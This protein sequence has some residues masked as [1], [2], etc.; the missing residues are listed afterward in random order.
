MI[1][2]AREIVRLAAA[3]RQAIVS[4]SETVAAE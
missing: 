4:Q 2:R 3:T 1:E